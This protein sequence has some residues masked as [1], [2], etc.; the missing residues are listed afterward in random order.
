MKIFKPL[1]RTFTVTTV[2]SHPVPV[3]T[4]YKKESP[5]LGLQYP[6]SGVYFMALLLVP[7]NNTAEPWA[8]YL[9]NRSL[10]KV[11]PL[12]VSFWSTLMA[13]ATFSF[14]ITESGIA[15]GPRILCAETVTAKMVVSQLPSMSQRT[16]QALVEPDLEAVRM[17]QESPRV[18]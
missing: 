9:I 13:M 1:Q 10:V 8:G 11:P 17:T 6:G 7:P 5:N 2:I 18:E 4:S 12:R 3:Q 15:T 14:V 16:K